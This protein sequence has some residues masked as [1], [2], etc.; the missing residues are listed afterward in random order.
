MSVAFIICEY[1]PF[2][3][4]HRYQF[5]KIREL[6]GDDTTI[7][8]LMSGST[9]QRGEV[10]VA[11]K[12]KRAAAAVSCGADL[13]LELPYPY[14]SLSAQQFAL[15]AVSIINDLSI[16]DYLVFGSENGD[17]SSLKKIADRRCS[18]EFESRLS[19]LRTIKKDLSY[20]KLV[21]HCYKDLYGEDF[22]KG[23]NDI[24]GVFYLSSLGSLGA[25][26][27]PLTHLRL[28]DASA[29]A[30][31]AMMKEGSIDRIPDDARAYFSDPPATLKKGERAILYALCQSRDKVLATAAYGSASYKEITQRLS[32]K[33]STD[34]NLRR[35]ILHGVIG[36]NE[37][38][39][40]LPKFTTLLAMDQSAG[41]LLRKAKKTS[42]IP[43]ITKPADYK[44]I[45]EIR[46]Q[47]ELNLRADALFALCCD[48]T[49]P[50]N[51]S[52]LKTPY[53]KK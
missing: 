10:A 8:S 35:T 44:E 46:A 11:D 23:P 19:V 13:V 3:N 14:C 52:I 18:N 25:N 22:P 28:P 32:N 29:T 48:E 5:A 27:I 33:N 2:H 40:S 4:G 39:F 24:L 31:R 53:V 36:Y 20:P 7:V 45:P 41:E 34:A 30:A 21:Q 51:W 47:F 43:I 15:A 42:R 26:L 37:K 6:L 49:L 12:Y 1:N 17:I 38:E 50:T 9:V 16:G